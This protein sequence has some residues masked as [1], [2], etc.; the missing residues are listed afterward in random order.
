VKKII[1][2]LTAFGLSGATAQE[3]TVSY[4][5]A[6]VHSPV[7]LTGTQ[8]DW[9]PTPDLAQ[10]LVP[11]S[12]EL[13]YAA[14]GSLTLLP[15]ITNLLKFFEGKQVMIRL[16]DGEIVKAI[17]IRADLALFE[18][19]GQYRQ[20]SPSQVIF[21]SLEGV[22]FEPTYQWQFT[23]AGG[24]T[25]LSYLTRALTWSP[26]YTLNV[27][28]DTGRLTAWADIRNAG[29]TPYNI[30]ELTLV[31]G[32]IN[33]ENVQENRNFQ[34]NQ[35][36]NFTAAR[37]EDV[38]SVQAV[39]ESAG[40]QIFKY[41]KALMLGGGTTTSVPFINVATKLERILDYTGFFSDTPRQV[42]PMQRLYR[43]QSDTD[44]P[45]GVVTV[46]EDNR[47]VGQ[48]RVSDT[49]K[50]ERANLFVGSDFDLRLTRTSQVITRT[51]TLAKFKVV[52]TLTNTKTRPINIRLR[53]NLGTNG[54]YT[55]DAV[56]LPN[57]RR[58]TEGLNA[59]TTLAPNQ[60]FEGSY[61]ITFKY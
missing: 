52:F 37:A 9:T 61:T 39:G 1:A 15:G 44:L 35:A 53:E 38:S 36:Q 41:P 58:E 31:A 5:F 23:G 34:S 26:R 27:S 56:S 6:E 54:N 10:F 33:L 11:G 20:I 50:A 60:K 51:N 7:T 30:P 3:L 42:L 47:V 29:A 2:L 55:L 18:I 8:F 57:L 13:E 22:R 12:L 16:E 45:S 21:P 24:K 40:L 46:R 19:N 43:V 48:A 25:N 4:N 59:S 32:Q 17:V 49:P 28:G 14:V